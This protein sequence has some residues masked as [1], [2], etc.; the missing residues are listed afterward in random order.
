MELVAADGA[1]EFDRA[2]GLGEFQNGEGGASALAVDRPPVHGNAPLHEVVAKLGRDGVV[3]ARGGKLVH[4]GAG[5]HVRP[6]HV[7]GRHPT[8]GRDAV[9]RPGGGG[10]ASLE[11]GAAAGRGYGSWATVGFGGIG[12]GLEASRFKS[13]ERRDLDGQVEPLGEEL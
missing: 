6:D 8:H 9:A 11:A 5:R 13:L 12:Q 4:T 3:G 1:V 7:E 10:E 2:P